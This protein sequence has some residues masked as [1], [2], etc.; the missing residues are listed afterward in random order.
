M[1]LKEENREA[2]SSHLKANLE[3]S[4]KCMELT[5]GFNTLRLQ[6]RESEGQSLLFS[7]QQNEEDPHQGAV[8]ILLSK[9]ARNNLI[10]WKPVSSRLMTASF[11]GRVRNVTIVQCYAPIEEANGD[12]KTRFYSQLQDTTKSY[13]KDILMVMGDLNAKVR[14]E[15]LGLEQVMGKHPLNASETENNDRNCLSVLPDQPQ[16]KVEGTGRVFRFDQVFGPEKSDAQ[17]YES[18]IVNCISF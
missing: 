12:L 15:N 1:R 16:I 5:E 10:D 4:K 2:M 13:S 3:I 18:S 6:A 17:I 11:K 7:G 14:S 9:R 8:G